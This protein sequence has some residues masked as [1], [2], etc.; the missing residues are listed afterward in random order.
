MRHSYNK[1]R[2]FICPILNLQGC[3]SFPEGSKKF[4]GS[5]GVPLEYASNMFTK[6]LPFTVNPVGVVIN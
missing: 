1:K 6:S 2:I 5:A 4:V 3:K